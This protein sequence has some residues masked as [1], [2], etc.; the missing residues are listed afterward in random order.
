MFLTSE[1]VV[2]ALLFA[3]FL[4]IRTRAEDLLRTKAELRKHTLQLIEYHQIS[5]MDEES[6]LK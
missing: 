4:V 1:E 2:T 5:R 6:I 3:A